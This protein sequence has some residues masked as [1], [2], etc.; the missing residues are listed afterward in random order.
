[1]SQKSTTGKLLSNSII[2]AASGLLLKCFSFFLL[3]LYTAYLTTEDYGI[4]SVATSF[5]TTMSYIVALSSFS[6]IM[7]FYVDL[8]EDPKKLK[9]F[10]GTIIS[11]VFLSGLL[12]GGLLTVFR[13]P[14]SK[15]VFSGADFFPVILICLIS[16]VFNCQH[17]VYSTILRSQQ[18]AIKVSILNVAYF[19][20]SLGLNVFFVVVLKRGATGVLLATMISNIVYTLFFLLDVCIRRE[21]TLCLDLKILKDSLKYSLPILPHNLS[22]Q[23]AV[24]ISKVLIGGA[25]SLGSL[26]I[27]SV[28]TQFG[29]IA[30]TIQT[31]VDQA[32]APWL[33][34][35]LKNRDEAYKKT[36]RKNASL[37][38]ACIGLFFIGLSLFAQDYIVLLV[39]KSY[40][41]AWK[42]VPLIVSVYAIKTIYYFYVALLFYHKKASRSLFIAT[43]SS[44]LL[45]I[46]LSYFAIP[47][48]GVYGSILADAIAM[49][50]RVAIVVIISKK[51]EDIGLYIRDFLLN[52]AIVELFIFGGLALSYLKFP[53][54][55]SIWNFVYK[56]GV[57]FLY[58]LLVMLRFKK[59]IKVFLHSRRKRSKGDL[60]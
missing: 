55:F 58:I 53:Y 20:L 10:Y 46:V 4:T 25:A 50:V 40:V 36:I 43:L 54:S 27:Y 15:Y 57:V 6:S 37:L 49:I 8:K 3:P 5:I 34:E 12:W 56:I 31:Y 48:W 35:K 17:T 38:C 22:T 2:Y 29:H 59:E 39:E 16:L 1:M 28:A 44:S 30:D 19:F 13:A 14:L 7:R 11:F 23:I 60:Q 45:N 21:I 9:R 41:E 42:Y 33:Y 24:L 18:R 47:L 32:Y 26:G 51:L 52:F